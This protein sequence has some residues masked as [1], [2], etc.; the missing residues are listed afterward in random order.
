MTREFPPYFVSGIG[1]YAYE[2]SQAAAEIGHRVTVVAPAAPGQPSAGRDAHTDVPVHTFRSGGLSPARSILPMVIALRR[3]LRREG[4]D[5]VHACERASLIA[6]KLAL[7]HRN[8]PVCVTVHGSETLRWRTSSVFKWM[9]PRLY[10]SAHAIAANSAYTS[11]QLAMM[12]DLGG[13]TESTPHKAIL[14][15]V[16]DWWIQ[17]SF[18]GSNRRNRDGPFVLGTLGRLNACKGHRDVLRACGHLP[19]RLRRRLTYL[20]IGSGRAGRPYLDELAQ[21][22]AD[23]RV[24]FEYAGAPD[25]TELPGLIRRMNAHVLYSKPVGHSV[26]GF[27][28]VMLEAA[29]QGVPTVATRL[30]GIPEVIAHNETGILVESGNSA[31]LTE[32]IRCLMDTPEL[33]ATLGREAQRR[34]ADRRWADVARETYGFFEESIVHRNRESVDG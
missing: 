23:A 17:N 26:E 33:V 7:G 21:E 22:A 18:A 6:A 12:L 5:L 30:G 1:T 29:T 20:V 27:G 9:D 34:A 28:L 8:T 13:V 19:E 14:L 2:I 11:E 15:A 10:R 32:A 25:R 24:G 31:A 4:F 16:G 3:R